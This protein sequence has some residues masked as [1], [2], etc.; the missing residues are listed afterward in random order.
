MKAADVL[1]PHRSTTMKTKQMISTISVATV[2][3]L[4]SPAYAA[5]LGGG[6]GGAMGGSLAGSHGGL[7]GA[8][9]GHG[10]LDGS[11]NSPSPKK[12]VDNAGAKAGAATK[13]A[14]EAGEKT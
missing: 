7:G 13:T 10:A 6:A 8:L 3:A 4:A 2:L 9:A 12:A 5:R 14:I 11:V 1:Q